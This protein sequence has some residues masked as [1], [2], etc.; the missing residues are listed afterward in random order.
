ME[1]SMNMLV[2]LWN[3]VIGWWF[4]WFGSDEAADWL[5]VKGGG[6]FPSVRS[7]WSLSVKI[8]SLLLQW[9]VWPWGH[10]CGARSLP[11][12]PVPLR[13]SWWFFRSLTFTWTWTPNRKW[14]FSKKQ[15][16][17]FVPGL[18]LVWQQENSLQEE[19]QQVPGG[20]QPLRDEDGVRDQAGWRVPPHPK[21]YRY[22]TRSGVCSSRTLVWPASVLSAQ[23]PGPS[24]WPVLPICSSVFHPWTAA[25]LPIR[26]ACR[27][28]PVVITCWSFGLWS[29]RADV[30][31]I[32]RLTGPGTVGPPPQQGPRP[33][34]TCLI[35][36]TEEPG[37]RA[38]ATE[39]LRRERTARRVHSSASVVLFFFNVL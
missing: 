1:R 37:R 19:H 22:E 33:T 27:W 7:L 18:Q 39:S 17:T 30:S 5:L 12:P 31:W 24:L 13:R 2:P 11:P 4:S 6:F 20:S 29:A 28:V 26:W 32:L 36:P 25:Q 21:L 14:R 8:I 16:T 35:T 15:N 10:V 34:A 38:T 23:G 9:T 3:N